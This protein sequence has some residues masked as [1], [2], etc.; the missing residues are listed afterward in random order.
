MIFCDMLP[1]GWVH[2]NQHFAGTAT[3]TCRIPHSEA[4]NFPETLVTTTKA[5]QW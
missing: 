2:I 4:A 5:N 1:C 3:S